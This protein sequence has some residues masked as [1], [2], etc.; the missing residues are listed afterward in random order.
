[1]HTPEEDAGMAREGTFILDSGDRFPPL[2]LD[3]VSHGRLTL[4]GGFGDGWGVFLLYRAH[5]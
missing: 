5:W 3:T 2:T 4:P 1:M